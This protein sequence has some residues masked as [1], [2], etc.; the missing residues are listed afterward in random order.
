MSI[1]VFTACSPE[2]L[3]LGN[4]TALG[5]RDYA[6]IHG[7]DFAERIHGPT[8]G[9]AWE[10]VVFWLEELKKT[11]WLWFS[12]CDVAVT[13]KCL[14]LPIDPACDFIFAADGNGL[15]SDSWLMRNCPATRDF[16]EM[17]LRWRGRANNEQDA[18]SVVLSGARDYNDFTREAGDLRCDGEP[19]SEGV[20]RRL[21]IALNRSPVKCKIVSQRV[22]NAY[23]F[24][25][26]GGNNDHPISWHPGDF[27]AHL[28]GKTLAYRLN[29]F[30]KLL[31][32]AF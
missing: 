21:E 8:D 3:P 14:P 2:Y 13:N 9:I 17:V 16:L 4:I 19:V 7:Y 1:R 18:M 25:C 23:P 32:Y 12:G 11:E 20:L 31:S 29:M 15:Q 27:V 22:L 30:P 6:I 28:P 24:E 26:Y 5:K 10:R